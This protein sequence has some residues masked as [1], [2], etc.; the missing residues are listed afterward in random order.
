MTY[1]DFSDF[2]LGKQSDCQ[3]I[4]FIDSRVN[5]VVQLLKKIVS[6]AVVV[7]L[8]TELDGIEQ[9]TQIL[10]QGNYHKVHIIADG[11]FGCLHLGS[12][13]LNLDTID[14]YYSQLRSWFAFD[15][16]SQ[17]SLLKKSLSTLFLYGCDVAEGDAGAEF[18]ARLSQITKVKVTAAVKLAAN[19]NP[20]QIEEIKVQTS[21]I[22]SSSSY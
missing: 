10:N 15:S 14:N 1:Y 20:D 22:E 3:I 17:T 16:N 6:N 9:I 21:K 5:N 8:E 4:V 19:V 7:I 12:S 18:V 2:V 11:S 13:Q